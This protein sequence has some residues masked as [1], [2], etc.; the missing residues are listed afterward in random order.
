MPS[1]KETDLALLKKVCLS[2][3]LFALVLLA[4]R[5]IYAGFNGFTACFADNTSETQAA[6]AG[7]DP[8]EM[9]VTNS[10]HSK[11]EGIRN[12][13]GDIALRL[14]R[15]DKTRDAVIAFYS[16]LTGNRD[17]TEIILKHADQNNISPS[18]AFALSWEE[19]RFKPTA[20]NRN[21]A[22]VDRGLFQLNSKAFPNLSE[23]E[24]FD[25]ETNASNGL[26]HLRYCI[27]Q[28]GNEV[29]AL[30]MYNAGATAVRNGKTPKRTLD[31]V[32]RILSYRENIDIGL[33]QFIAEDIL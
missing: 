15:S 9:L 25:P 14:Y 24:M 20:V 1:N 29:A 22:S 5:I 32:S 21:P 7:A 30:A 18:L 11:M 17:I 23:E 33:I 2:V 8:R 12:S 16:E 19:S 10:E 6:S 31:Y 3:F 27:D 13:E 4:G 28:S 26:S